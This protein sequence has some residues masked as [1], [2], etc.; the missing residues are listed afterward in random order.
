MSPAELS[1]NDAKPHEERRVSHEERGRNTK[2]PSPRPSPE[3]RGLLKSTFCSPQ[4]ISMFLAQ[5]I[6]DRWSVDF[7]LLAAVPAE[8]TFT[9][10]APGIAARPYV[11]LFIP[12]RASR[13]RTSSGAVVRQSTV[14]FHVWSDQRAAARAIAAVVAR[15]F[16]RATFAADGWRVL[17]MRWTRDREEQLADG[18]WRVV[19]EFQ[20]LE[21]FTCGVAAHG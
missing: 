16:D 7:E 6:H 3:G 18:A 15:R 14:E 2:T 4:A 21:S 9:G 8:R 13:R 19:V 5:A 17:D 1:R 20:V 12:E 11:A 10:A